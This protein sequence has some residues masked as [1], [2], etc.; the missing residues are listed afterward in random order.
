MFDFIDVSAFGGAP[1][2]GILALLALLDSTSFGTLLIPIWL[3]LA[4]GRVR[5]G[6]LLLY[7][8]TIVAF[9]FAVGLVIAFGA[10]TFMEEITA[11][12]ATQP[13]KWL[14]LILGAGLLVFSFTIDG[15]KKRE[16]DGPGRLA[17]WRARAMG[18]ED[19]AEGLGAGTSSLEGAGARAGTTVAAKR[20]SALALM[21]LALTAAMIELASM[22]PYLAGIGLITTEGPGWPGNAG[23]LAGYCAVMVAPA[24][25]LLGA[26]LVA[27]RAIEP[28]LQR[29]NTWLTKNAASTTAWVVG[30][31]GF[32]LARD[33]GTQ[34]GLFE[35][36]GSVLDG[37]GGGG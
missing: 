33:A 23:L 32:L 11:F 19:A 15:K 7:L 24:L 20:S 30:I 28:L 37:I 4:P 13:A 27:A 26:R 29:L 35:W 12:L 34:L 36:V 17:R 10:S 16:G 1:L 18:G 6:R 5:P 22:L 2:Y 9:Y 31:I 21:A 8:G 14:Q 3:L 25:L